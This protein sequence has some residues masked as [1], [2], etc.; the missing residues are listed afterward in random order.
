M[1]EKRRHIR[2]EFSGRVKLIHENFGEREV[3]LHDLSNGGIFVLVREEL[4]LQAGNTIKVQS[5]DIDDAPI[6]PAEVVRLEA[7]GIALKFIE[8]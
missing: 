4:G 6:L 1:Q 3:E 2:T 7:R 8:G 5:L